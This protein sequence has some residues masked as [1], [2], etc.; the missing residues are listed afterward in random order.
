MKPAFKCF[1]LC[2]LSFDLLFFRY[3][4]ALNPLHHC[5]CSPVDTDLALQYFLQEMHFTWSMLVKDSDA[6]TL[7]T[8]LPA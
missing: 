6:L 5:C 1:G 3:M 2:E 4:M 7:P 8:P